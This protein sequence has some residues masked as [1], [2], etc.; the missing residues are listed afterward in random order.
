MTGHLQPASPE[1]PAEPRRAAR[2]HRLEGGRSVK[3]TVR[4]SDAEYDA[5]AARA[6]SAGVNAQRFL[7]DSALASR[8]P[9][10][11]VPAALT[12][13]LSGI[14]RLLGS[15]SNNMNQ[16]ARWLNSGGRPDARVTAAMDA[17][18]RATIRLDAVLGWLAPELRN[19][20]GRLS[21]SADVHS[22]VP[23]RL[24]DSGMADPRPQ[25]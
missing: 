19:A 25:A 15:L 8:R 7:V 1:P 9:Q 12:A 23:E 18:R 20:S 14:R 6:D 13:E 5:I 24:R 10:A 4:L 11:R 2:R 21:V 16:I 3:L 22:A 17:V